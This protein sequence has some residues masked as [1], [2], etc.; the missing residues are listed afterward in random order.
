MKKRHWAGVLLAALLAAVLIGVFP[1][2]PD[3]DNRADSEMDA[4]RSI[5]PESSGTGVVEAGSYD[6][7]RQR[8]QT[9]GPRPASLSGTEVDG[10][11]QVTADG[12]LRISPAIRQ[13]FDYFLTAL[14]E[15]SLEDIQARL[16]GHLGEQL[17]PQAAQQ[18]WA[19]YERYMALRHAMEALPEHDGSAAGMR[20]AIRQR[21]DLQQTYLG[22]EAADAFYGLDMAYDRYMTERQALNEDDSL[23]ELQ[24]EQQRVNL[25]QN[26]P[27]A[28]QQM[29]QE[30]RAPARLEQRTQALREQGASD[31]EIRALREQT[32]GAQAADRFEA[33]EQQRQDWG[34]RYQAYRQQ[35]RQVINSGLSHPDQQVALARLQQQLFEESELSRVQALDR[36][37]AQTP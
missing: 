6:H 11:L 31:A 19:L 34:R 7:Y 13:V 1:G 36:I 10:S 37:N 17:P 33:L 35:R 23:T 12:D 20:A 24:R 28:M 8:A 29:L 26:L 4:G 30:T 14:G 9:L 15:E 22:A 27:D 18:A 21:H 16:A 5:A 25:E 2:F 32:F 3:R